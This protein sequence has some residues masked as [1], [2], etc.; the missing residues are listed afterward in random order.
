MAK[1]TYKRRHLIG[2]LLVVSEG[3]SVITMTRQ[4]GGMQAW[5]WSSD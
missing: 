5:C 4:H 3:E 1:G 2:R